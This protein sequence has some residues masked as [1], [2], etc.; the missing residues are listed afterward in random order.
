MKCVYE[1]QL[2]IFVCNMFWVNGTESRND[3]Y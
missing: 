1:D 2:H 3:K